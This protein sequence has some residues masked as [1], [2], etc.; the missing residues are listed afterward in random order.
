MV[1][2]YYIVASTCL[3]VGELAYHQS[4]GA[5]ILSNMVIKSHGLQRGQVDRQTRLGLHRHFSGMTAI[6]T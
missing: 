1:I 2:E 4:V 5:D 3:L 6:A